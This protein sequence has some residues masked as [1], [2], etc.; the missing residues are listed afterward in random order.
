M[1]MEAPAPSERGD[2][3]GALQTI[4]EAATAAGADVIATEASDLLAR[5][6]EGRFF[7]ACLGQFKRGK[8]TMLNALLGEAV[9]PTG[10][11]PVTSA[12]TILRHGGS[13]VARV[14]YRSGASAE[15]PIAQL[16][17]YVTERG[18]PGNTKGVAVV[19][20]SHPS[21]L[22]RHGLCLV[23]TPGLG[24]ASPLATEVTRAF[25][26]HVDAALVVTGADPPLTGDEVQ[27]IEDLHEDTEALVFA[28]NKADKLTDAE[29]AEALVFTQRLLADRMGTVPDQL[30]VVSASERLNAGH[31]TRDWARLEQ[32]L[33]NLGQDAKARLMAHR[34]MRVQ[35]RLARE[36]LQAIDL[37]TEALVAPLDESDRKLRDLQRWLLDAERAVSDLGVL[38][39][40]EQQNI[41]RKLRDDVTAGLAGQRQAIEAELRVAVA[42]ALDAGGPHV[43]QNALASAQGIAKHAVRHA[44]TIEE[45][46]AAKS[47]R[48]AT[49]RFVEL[50][51]GLLRRLAVSEPRLADLPLVAT[52]S[53]LGGKRRFYFTAMMRLTARTPWDVLVDLFAPP[54]YRRERLI[55]EATSYLDRLLETNTSRVAGDLDDRLLESRRELEA[56]VRARL[57]VLVS[58]ASR[59]L[60]RAREL[61]AAGHAAVRGELQR[62]KGLRAR[63]EPFT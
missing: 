10:V 24:S 37:A 53:A 61:R 23:D 21:P 25:V 58:S 30:F 27:L 3:P 46:R 60:D 51:N 5:V 14:R 6:A 16:A 43:R 36:L 33:M 4:A 2:P 38:L 39:A 29:L 7:V 56:E 31:A 41:A 9:L 12:V 47:Y 48:E 18:N 49:E 52:S 34:V 42:R 63:V 28:M 15:V 40:A 17:D 26:P 8:S 22:L 45:Q 32:A 13:K 59:A 55:A 50:A 44:L 35:H 11:V 57:T 62:L 1:L 20:V 54:R 19:E